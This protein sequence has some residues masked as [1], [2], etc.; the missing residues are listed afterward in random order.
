[1][2]TSL[3]CLPLVLAVALQSGCGGSSPAPATSAAP[4]QIVGTAL[5]S[6][7]HPDM[8]VPALGPVRA[9]VRVQALSGP[10]AGTVV[11]RTKPDTHGRF[12]LSLPPGTYRVCL[13]SGKIPYGGDGAA[14]VTV[15]P[16]QVTRVTLT[17]LGL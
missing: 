9:P 1:V 4:G 7:Q 13:M 17:I 15:G 12:A 16:G 10:S 3:A 6:Y 2:R 14:T 8:P 5:I 11:A